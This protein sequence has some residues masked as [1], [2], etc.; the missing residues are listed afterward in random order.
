MSLFAASKNQ[1]RYHGMVEVVGSIPIR[2]TICQ[3][4]RTT[5]F[6]KSR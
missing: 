2:S 3:G 5:V 6:K 1:R 4:I